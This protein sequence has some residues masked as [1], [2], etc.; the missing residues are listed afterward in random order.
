MRRILHAPETCALALPR[1]VRSL[2][3]E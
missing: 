1:A 2:P 3:S